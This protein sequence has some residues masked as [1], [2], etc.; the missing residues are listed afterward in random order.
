MQASAWLLV[1]AILTVLS[2][3]CGEVVQSMAWPL[4]GAAASA[5][6]AMLTFTGLTDMLLIY[7][8]DLVLQ[9]SKLAVSPFSKQAILTCYLPS[10]K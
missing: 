1:G 7:P 2:L 10:R 5:A 8:P 4:L 6:T 9:V 3:V